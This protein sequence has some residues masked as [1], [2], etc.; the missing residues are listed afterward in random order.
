MRVFKLNWLRQSLFRLFISVRISTILSLTLLASSSLS[1]QEKLS[2]ISPQEAGYSA[3]KLELLKQFLKNSGTESMLLLHDGKLL[4]EFG[5]LHQ[6]RSVHSI[7]K[8]LLNGVYGSYLQQQ[9]LA[10]DALL[11]SR[12]SDWQMDDAPNK[13]NALEKQTQLQY[14][15]QSR[16]GIYL[17]A[18]AESDGMVANK[19][20]RNS[21]PAGSFFYYNN[22]DFN[23]A[24]RIAETWSGKS[25]YRM[26][27]EMIAQ[28][29][30]MVDYQN[31]IATLHDDQSIDPQSALDGYYQYELEK[32]RFPAYHFRLSSYDLALYGQLFLNQGEWHGKQ[33]ISK[34]WI[35]RSTTP[36][37]IINPEYGLAY[38]M[39]WNVLV[40]DNADERPSFYHTGVD[41]HMLGIYPKH[42]LVMVHRVNTEQAHTFNEAS[43]YKIIRMMHDARFKIPAQP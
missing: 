35:K 4:F 23:A 38:G 8:A 16:S 19:P 13:L 37:S 21:H 36:I 27:N 2:K 39:L 26:F 3:E 17:P 29:I 40:P 18:T 20:S 11:H 30:G 34:E 41:I 5:D 28:P 12:L 42:K 7:R 22:W 33:I 32:S 1:A 14:L 24:G 43:L 25:I 15:L 6:K 10:P 9:G 31:T